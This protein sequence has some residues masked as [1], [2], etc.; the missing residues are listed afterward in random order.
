MI[1]SVILLCHCSICLAVAAAVP[2]LQQLFAAQA[3][4]V[5]QPTTPKCPPPLAPPP[6]PH[7]KVTFVI[8]KRGVEYAAVKCV[9][10]MAIRL[11]SCAAQKAQAFFC[12]FN[13]VHPFVLIFIIC[14]HSLQ[15]LPAFLARLP[16]RHLD[17]GSCRH[18]NLALIP[19]MTQLEVLSLSVSFDLACC[20]Q[21]NVNLSDPNL[22]AGIFFFLL[23]ENCL[24]RTLHEKC[25]HPG[26]SIVRVCISSDI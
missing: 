8:V 25:V 16:L 11:L 14:H 22:K 26:P 19:T 17:L 6:L 12:L 9:K 5:V 4:A 20:Q 7:Q 23:I 24:A 1:L 21:C 3:V 15:V 2:V 10:V 18:L 13:F